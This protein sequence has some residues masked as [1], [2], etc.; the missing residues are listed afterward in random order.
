[1]YGLSS[2]TEDRRVYLDPELGLLRVSTLEI[3]HI[4]YL[5]K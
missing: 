4:G 2:E 5:E 3:F 1:M